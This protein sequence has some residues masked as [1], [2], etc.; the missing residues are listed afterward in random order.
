[1]E[2]FS[3]CSDG[4]ESACN[5]G[6]PYLIPE[7]GRSPREGNCYTPQYSRLENPVDR[8]ALWAAIHGITEFDMTKWLTTLF[9]A[10]GRMRAGDAER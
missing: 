10:F 7:S 3:D 8:G 6:D 4:K 9:I 5:A 2:G 1:M